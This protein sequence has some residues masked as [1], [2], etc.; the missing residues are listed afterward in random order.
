[1]RCLLID[2]SKAFDMDVVDYTV[3]VAIYSVY[4][5]ALLVV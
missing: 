3:L 4:V 1:M 2:F 5:N